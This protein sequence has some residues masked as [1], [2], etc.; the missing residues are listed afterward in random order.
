MKN[1][2]VFDKIEDRRV[3]Q[4]AKWGNCPP[5]V[6]PMTIADMDFAVP[7]PIMDAMKKRLEHPFFGYES[8]SREAMA[9]VPVFYRDYFGCEVKSDW[10]V[11]VLAV[12]PGVIVGASL[13][14]GS[15][16]YCTPMYGN[17]RRVGTRLHKPITEVPMRYEN[18]R[19][20][21]DFDAMERAYTP[22]VTTFILCS[23]H[24]PVGRVFTKEELTGVIDFCERHDL[25]LISDEIHCEFDFD[26]RHT[27]LFSLC[28]GRKVRSITLTSPG[29]TCNIPK[30]SFGIAIIP[31]ETLRE[32]Y[33]DAIHGLFASGSILDGAAVAKAYDGSC[34]AWKNELRSYLIGNRDYLD[35][36]FESIPLL[37]ANHCEGTYLCWIDCTGLK[38]EDPVAYLEENAKVRLGSGA[39]FGDAFGGF[40]RMNFACP[41]RV[42]A[43]ALDRLA[44]CAEKRAAE[45]ALAE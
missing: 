43:E 30:E 42:L 13:G 16:M 11:F 21:F 9:Q 3:T 1:E 41:R 44:A 8:A 32:Q 40:V 29:K 36:R 37:R 2:S 12:M 23:P 19:Y 22:D 6:I 38:V 26:R 25:L 14:G 20:L 35:K 33:V 27:P 28:E 45:L 5:D 10:L 15:I 39:N 17:I 4:G 18:G 34:A 24:N 31:D 7:Q